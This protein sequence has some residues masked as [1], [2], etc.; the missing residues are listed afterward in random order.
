MSA[1]EQLAPYINI[2]V[3]LVHQK[4]VAKLELTC[5]NGKVNINISHELNINISHVLNINI[6]HVL[7]INI[8]H[9]LNINISHELNINIFH[10]LG[11]FVKTCQPLVQ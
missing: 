3:A 1:Q 8:S 7:N 6:S 4:A 9:E 11:E 5:T 10:E 2:F